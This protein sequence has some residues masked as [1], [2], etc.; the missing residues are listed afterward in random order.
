LEEI[1]VTYETVPIADLVL[2]P[3]NPRTIS[4]FDMT[5][6]RNSIREFGVVQPV[7]VR[8]SDRKVIAGH[9]RI[10]ALQLE[11]KAEVSVIWWEGDDRKA[12]ALALALNK[13]QG[14]WVQDKL[15]TL[16]A[17]LADVE[18]LSDALS[19]FDSDFTSLAG[20]ST[21]ESL[22][23]FEATLPSG[24]PEENLSSLSAELLVRRS[25]Q[26]TV[27]LGDLFQ[28]GSHRVLC[29]DAR[30][31]GTVERL[32]DQSAPSMLFT[33]PPYNV[34]Y[35]AES[36][37]GHAASG[38]SH[39]RR[40]NP[41]GPIAEDNLPPSEYQELLTG[42]LRNAFKVLRGGGAV[43]VCGGTSTTTA[44]DTAFT[45]VGL[46]KSSIIIWDKGEFSLGRK[47]YQ[48][49][50][51]LIYY[52]W[53]QGSK[54]N[55]YGGRSQT[56][57]W[58]IPRDASSSYLHP[59]QKPTA[60]AMRAIRN[61]STP[62]EAVLDLFGGS[63]STL[64]AAEQTGRKALLLELDPHYVEVAVARWEALT[65]KKAVCIAREPADA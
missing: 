13:I 34:A 21:K 29:G 32:C 19:G 14:E 35:Q 7:V 47:D 17:E 55:F 44:Y 53:K 3:R 48:S 28:L 23:L 15:G 65:G 5:K 11:G 64:I 22:A 40:T 42:S 31:Q 36:V 33:D 10:T 63:G 45:S 4:D 9:Q 54:H 6:L 2:D 27:Q 24:L 25:F 8:R 18:S 62:G 20:F 43:Y 1:Q 38:R 12:Y 50:Y 16:L 58:L 61:S 41:L 46:T 52:G 37:G 30:D 60:L 57:I 51:E 49:A 59:T 39:G 56:D 26:G